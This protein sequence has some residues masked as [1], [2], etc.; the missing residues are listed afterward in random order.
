MRNFGFLYR[1]LNMA[2]IIKFCTGGDC[3]KSNGL[4]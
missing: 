1:Q 3:L 2:N 4:K